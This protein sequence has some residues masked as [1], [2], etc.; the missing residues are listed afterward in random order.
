MVIASL[1]SRRKNWIS[2]H[3]DSELP[4]E[5]LASQEFAKSHKKAMF[6]LTLRTPVRNIFCNAIRVSLP[7]TTQELHKFAK[8]PLNDFSY[9]FYNK[10]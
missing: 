9:N 10:R 6:P 7:E 2:L 3:P 8:R 1:K 4:T 5:A